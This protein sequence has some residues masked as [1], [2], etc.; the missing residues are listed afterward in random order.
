M[1]RI[2]VASM[3]GKCAPAPARSF[4]LSLLAAF[5][6][7]MLHL[8]V[9]L[10]EAAAAE[11][12]GPET[13]IAARIQRLIPDLEAYIVSGMQAFDVPG[14]AIGIVTGDRLVYGKGFGVRG[15]ASGSPV[16]TR[17]LFQIGSTTKA[18]LATTMAMT[19][20]RRKFRWDDR[21]VDLEPT[22]QL[23]DPWV[24]REFRVFDL[25]A[26]RSGLPPYANDMVG[27]LGADASAMIQ[28]LR[29]V[30][31]ISSFR[32]SFAYTN[33]TH[34]LAARIVA[35]LHGAPDWN[36]FAQR[37]ILDPLGM[38]DTSFTA[39][40][41]AV[42]ANHSEGYRWTPD[43][44]VEVPFDP[45]FPYGFGAAG[46]INSNVED[47]ARWVRLQL[48]DGTFESRSIVSAENL[49]VTRTPKVAITEKVSYALGWIVQQ[50]PNGAV[51]WH[52]GGT[53]AFGAYVGMLVDRDVGVIVLTNE[54]N[55]GFPDAIGAW[56]ADR[57]LDNPPVDHVANTLKRATA[58][59]EDDGKMFTRPESP[60]PFPPLAPLAG[61]YINSSFGRAAVRLAGD[62][63]AMELQTT[64]AQLKLEP[65]DGEVFTA[66]LMP[67]GRFRATV[68]NLG[69]RP[70]GFAQFQIDAKGEL[71]VLRL[72]FE[73]GQAYEFRREDPTRPTSLE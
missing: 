64:G 8:N 37:E 52:N 29:Y 35:R 1:T 44:T 41:I 15:K 10:L 4:L 47:M 63:L 14:L 40:A 51:I 60:R 62:A 33:I 58:R 2:D 31:P 28:S 23:S 21:V 22:F 3:R 12:E 45:I 48:G 13:P 49:A 36:A 65:W 71:G 6:L 70:N 25:I 55:V 73:D 43:G 7:A 9:S 38:T 61:S 53:S 16:D 26:Q 5:V 54:Q 17:T 20:D 11:P 59:F 18:F 19:V 34:L 30:D 27:L 39:D 46:N 42:A 56:L 69:P 50:T 57:L 32:S 72:S 66:R 67:V 24:T 68:E